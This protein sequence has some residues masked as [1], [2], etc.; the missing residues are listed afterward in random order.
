[1][2]VKFVGQASNNNLDRD[3][4]EIAVFTPDEEIG[5]E[6]SPKRNGDDF[7][8]ENRG[9][10]HDSIDKNIRNWYEESKFI[11]SN[12]NHHYYSNNNGTIELIEKGDFPDYC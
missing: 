6:I 10:I 11:T 1:M 7:S 8:T 4:R 5:C 2:Q 9:K 12:I 3:D